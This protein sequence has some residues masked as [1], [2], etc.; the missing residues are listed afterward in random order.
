M[1][2]IRKLRRIF[3][4]PMYKELPQR[5]LDDI[6]YAAVMNYNVTMVI[7]ND[8][9]I[10]LHNFVE[11]MREKLPIL[12][13]RECFALRELLPDDELFFLRCYYRALYIF[14]LGKHFLG[15]PDIPP[16]IIRHFFDHRAVKLRSLAREAVHDEHRIVDRLGLEN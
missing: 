14:V 6:F 16:N 8:F 13:R 1:N 2:V 3:S 4:S 7:R 9:P 12:S 10:K 15:I 5:R 11:G